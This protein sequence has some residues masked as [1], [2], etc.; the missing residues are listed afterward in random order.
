MWCSSLGGIDFNGVYKFDNKLWVKLGNPEN[1]LII[2]SNLDLESSLSSSSSLASFISLIST[3][4]A[5]I[6]AYY[7][8]SLNDDTISF[9]YVFTISFLIFYFTISYYSKSGVEGL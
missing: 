8:F 1:L 4:S 7:W 9:Y 2:D 6:F 3:I 5:I